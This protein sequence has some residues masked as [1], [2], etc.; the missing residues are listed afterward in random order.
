MPLT[1]KAVPCIPSNSR[2]LRL[3]VVYD[4]PR[5]SDEHNDN[6]SKAFMQ[7]QIRTG[8]FYLVKGTD[9]ASPDND[10]LVLFRDIDNCVVYVT[11]D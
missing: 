5:G 3:E 2:L 8:M 7:E 9:P 4:F 6:F 10:T 1:K 11:K